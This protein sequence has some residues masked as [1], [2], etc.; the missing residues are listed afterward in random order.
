MQFDGIGCV[1]IQLLHTE[2]FCM[3]VKIDVT[4][5]NNNPTQKTIIPITNDFIFIL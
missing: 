5:I 1:L 4:N 2:K 3:G